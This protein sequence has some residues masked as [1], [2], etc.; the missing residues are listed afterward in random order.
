MY[1]WTLLYISFRNVWNWPTQHRK[2]LCWSP[3][4]RTYVT[5]SCLVY[6]RFTVTRRN[7]RTRFEPNLHVSCAKSRFALTQ[8]HFKHILQFCDACVFLCNVWEFY[9][10]GVR[11]RQRDKVYRI[12]KIK[13]KNKEHKYYMYCPIPVCREN[14][15]DNINISELG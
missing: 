10:I 1:I 4:K 8:N 13:S 2:L 15:F 9:A 14:C 5:K 11:Q 6:L 3:M 7:A 12:T